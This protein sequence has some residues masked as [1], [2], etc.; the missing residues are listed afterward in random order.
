[1]PGGGGSGEQAGEPLSGQQALAGVQADG[2]VLHHTPMAPAAG[3]SWQAAR[4]RRRPVRLSRANGQVIANI[5]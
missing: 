1:V 3:P 5:R 2:E 4:T